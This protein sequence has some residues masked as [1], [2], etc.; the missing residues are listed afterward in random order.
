MLIARWIGV[1]ALG[2]FILVRRDIPRSLAR[3]IAG[4][5]VLSFGIV[6]VFIAAILQLAHLG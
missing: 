2:V 5:V 6:G 4:G 1:V 3:T